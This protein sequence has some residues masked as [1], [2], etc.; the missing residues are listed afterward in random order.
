MFIFEDEDIH[1]QHCGELIGLSKLNYCAYCGAKLEL[2]GKAPD[3]KYAYDT[4]IVE[5]DDY[6]IY[7]CPRCETKTLHENNYC[8][9]CGLKFKHLKY[10]DVNTL[11]PP[12]FTEVWGRNTI[13]ETFGGYI[14][15][16]TSSITRYSLIDKYNI[17]HYAI[18]EWRFK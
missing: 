13:D 14:S 3:Y 15:K 2:N 11:E 8:T 12:Q 4:C 16:D 1:C 10:I 5:G 9:N 6:A 7:K 17:H 18:K